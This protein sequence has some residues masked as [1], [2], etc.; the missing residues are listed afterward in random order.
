[1][2]KI[3]IITR[4]SGRPKTFDRC[5]RSIKNQTYKNINHIVLYDDYRSKEYLDQYKDI[6]AV[7]VDR[8]YLINTQTN[9]RLENLMI[10]KWA[11]HNLYNNIGLER[12]KEGFYMFLDD[13]DYLR[14]NFVI[15]QL[16][17]EL[18]DRD[19]LYVFQMDFNGVKVPSDDMI[20][21]RKIEL[22]NIGSP[23]YLI[24][25]KYKDSAFWDAFKC[26]DYRYVRDISNVIPKTKFIKNIVAKIDMI[27]DGMK[28]DVA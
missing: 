17:N 23:C 19:T 20:D 8:D 13:D 16:V 14:N 15:Q 6:D 3:N 11:P 24:P 22:F 9:R 2:E 1:M 4:T 26:A 7:L 21:R 5:Y 18:E 12:L 10:F 25:V 27:G 28:R